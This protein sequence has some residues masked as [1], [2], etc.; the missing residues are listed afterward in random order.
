MIVDGFTFWNELDLLEIRLAE[1]DP[2]VDRFVLV[3]APLTFSGK[4]KPLHFADNRDRYR[5]WADKIVHVVADDIPAEWA[6]DRWERETWQRNAIGRGLEGLRADD[7]ILLGD[8]DEIPTRAIVKMASELCVYPVMFIQRLFYYWLNCEVGGWGGTMALRGCDWIGGEAVRMLRGTIV[9][10]VPD[11]GWHFSFMGDVIE[12]I[13][14]FAHAEV[15]LPHHKDPDIIAH[16]RANGID[17]FNRGDYA[18]EFKRLDAS[19]PAAVFQD[20]KRYAHLLKEPY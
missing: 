3:E 14:S 4:P 13:E 9:G 6:K 2:I 18:G 5:R 19:W 10:R 8:V 15:D 7:L 16:N 17:P 12:K 20:S 11:A 1:L